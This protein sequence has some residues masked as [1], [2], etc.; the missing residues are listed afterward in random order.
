MTA[1]RIRGNQHGA[2]KFSRGSN[3]DQGRGGR[4]GQSG[5]CHIIAENHWNRSLYFVRRESA[6]RRNGGSGL[7][8]KSAGIDQWLHG[9]EAS[10]DRARISHPASRK[11]IRDANL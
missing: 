7:A 2:I 6:R 9:G 4:V 8:L 1:P 10:I 5:R 3:V 11:R